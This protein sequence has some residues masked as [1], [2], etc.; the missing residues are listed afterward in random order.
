VSRLPYITRTKLVDFKKRK[1]GMVVTFSVLLHINSIRY[2]DVSMIIS[3]HSNF[4]VKQDSNSR[5]SINIHSVIARKN[6]LKYPTSSCKPDMPR[7]CVFHVPIN[8]HLYHHVIVDFYVLDAQQE[9]S[10]APPL[11]CRFTALPSSPFSAIPLC[12]FSIFTSNNPSVATPFAF[13]SLIN[14]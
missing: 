6:D 8:L 13:M 4:R 11:V 10:Q 3:K 9:T 5:V 7:S 12:T 1:R 14:R 2:V